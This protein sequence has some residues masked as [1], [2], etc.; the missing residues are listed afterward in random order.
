MQNTLEERL[1]K[2]KIKYVQEMGKHLA[3][4]RAT[5]PTVQLE[6]HNLEVLDE[7]FISA[8]TIRGSLGM[9]SLITTTSP[10]LD[11]VAIEIERTA[12]A[13]RK[14]EIE[15]A[16]E[17]LDNFYKGIERLEISLAA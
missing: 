14:G 16:P 9:M 3:I 11:A 2:L 8:H 15:L 5:L 7:L 1:A 10:D 12:A 4:L 17:V 6:P 13:L